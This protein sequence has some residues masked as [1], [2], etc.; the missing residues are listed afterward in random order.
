VRKR[1]DCPGGS[2]GL[3]SYLTEVTMS[4]LACLPEGGGG[5]LVVALLG[6]AWLGTP[7][8]G[9]T[10]ANCDR[11]QR[12]MTLSEVEALFGEPPYEV[13]DFRDD[14]LPVPIGATRW[15]AWSRKWKAA[16]VKVVVMFDVEDKVIEAVWESPQD[17]NFVG[18]ISVGPEQTPFLARLRSWLACSRAAKL[19]GIE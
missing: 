1:D 17:P 18:C 6:A 3:A 14:H 19:L 13:C 2:T 7:A 4:M 16:A 5:F 11:L 10:K 15:V 9:V 8:A 12:G